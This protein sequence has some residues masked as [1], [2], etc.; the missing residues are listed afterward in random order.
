V[1]MWMTSTCG[2]VD[3]SFNY[4]KKNLI[5]SQKGPDTVGEWVNTRILASSLAIV[6]R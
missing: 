1:G 6:Q 5:E 3:A 2:D 4:F